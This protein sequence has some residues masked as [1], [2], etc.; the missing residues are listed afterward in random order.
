MERNP[1]ADIAYVMGAVKKAFMS[2]VRYNHAQKRD[3]S[4]TCSLNASF[5]SSEDDSGCLLDLVGEDN[6][7]VSAEGLMENFLEEL[8][9]RFGRCY[10]RGIK[11]S[12]GRGGYK[13]RI[14]EITRTVID[15]IH[16]IPRGEI[17]RKVNYHFFVE[18]GLGPFLWIFYK[19]SPVRAVTDAY[20]GKIFPWEFRK[21][22]Q[23][24]WKGI[25]GYRNALDAT[26]WFC[27][28][29]E[30]ESV[31]DCRHV[32]WRDFKEEG[33]DAM[34]RILFS[35]SPYLALKTRFPDLRPWQTN[36]TSAGYFEDRQHRFEALGF[37]LMEHGVPSLLGL[38]SEEVYEYGLRLFVTSGDLCEKG[39]RG[40]LKQYNGRV[41]QMFCDLYPGK[42]L[43]WTL[44]RCKEPWR[45][46]PRET[47]ARAIR[48]LF[49]DYLK[50]PVHEIPDYA[51]CDLF[52]R[53]GFSGILTNKQIGYS[54]SPYRAV[55]SAYPGRFSREDFKRPRWQKLPRLEV[56]HLKKDRR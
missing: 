14:R 51:T 25:E 20:V 1:E 7:P 34:L 10:L 29:R 6:E 28:K 3:T 16:R 12:R 54:S 13:E 55:D 15:E 23:R 56:K 43:P 36:Q 50:I 49:E 9:R 33:L 40:L 41:Y 38:T 17:P 27:K 18:N 42:I 32:K 11:S 47:G 39:F 44:N 53:V 35:D 52:W 22:P 8:R 21:K 5:D 2:R 37:Y 19:N 46:N 26:E 48:W 4:R 45:D 30:I 24:F 31:D